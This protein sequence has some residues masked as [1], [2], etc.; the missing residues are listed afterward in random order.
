MI[1]CDEVLMLKETNVIISLMNQFMYIY[2]KPAIPCM[3]GSETLEFYFLGT[4]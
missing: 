3:M 4:F 2:I 1:L